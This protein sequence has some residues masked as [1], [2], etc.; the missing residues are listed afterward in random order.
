MIIQSMTREERQKC[1][2]ALSEKRFCAHYGVG[3]KAIKAL[4]KDMKKVYPEMKLDIE[5]VLM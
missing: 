3:Q 1:T 2:E 5:S 4:I